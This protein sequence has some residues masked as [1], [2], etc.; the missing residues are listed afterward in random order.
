MFPIFYT[1]SESFVLRDFALFLV[2]WEGGGGGCSG[3]WGDVKGFLGGCSGFLGCSMMFQ[4]D[5]VFL[6]ILYANIS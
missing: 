1:C 5:P 4:D 3:F 2:F 6:K